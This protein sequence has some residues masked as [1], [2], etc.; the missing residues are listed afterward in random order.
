MLYV[1]SKYMNVGRESQTVASSM[2]S[3]KRATPPRSQSCARASVD[4]QGVVVRRHAVARAL[5]PTAELAAVDHKEHHA[6]EHADA[7]QRGEEEL[8]EGGVV[9][10]VRLEDADDHRE[11]REATVLDRGHHP[12]CGA[13]LVLRDG[14]L[15]GGPERGGVDRVRDALADQRDVPGRPSLNAVRCVVY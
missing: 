14:R 8:D 10:E 13:H 6:G 7:R 9:V 4:R 2:P 15:D 1:C 3:G 11:E 12:V 5:E